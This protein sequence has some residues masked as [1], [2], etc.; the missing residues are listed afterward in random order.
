[1]A[2]YV[3][4]G[5]TPLRG[6]ITTNTTKN[7]TIAI[8][9]ASLM[10]KGKVVIKDVPA[11]EEVPRIIEI[12]E[13]IGVLVSWKDQHTIEIDSSNSLTL[14]DIHKKAC[15]R[16]RA[17]LLLMGALAGRA[18][19]TYKLYKSGGCKLGKRTVRPHVYAL[20]KLGI[21]VASK[22]R[23]YEVTNKKLQAAD[24]VMYEAG[25][26][27]TENAIMAAVLASGKT[28][29]KFASANY[30][31]QD[32]CYFLRAAGAKI[33]G[34]GTTTLTITGV[35]NL[36]SVT[37]YAIMPDPIEAFAWISLGVT[38]QSPI[39]IKNCPVDF[40][41]L[42][43]EKLRIMGQKFSFQK[44]RTSKNGTFRIADIVLKP[45][46]LTALQDKISCQPFPGLNID[47][48]PFFGPIATQ[49]EGRTLIH[50]WVYENRALYHLEMQKLGANVMLLDPH[51]VMIEGKTPLVANEALCPPAIRPGMALLIAMVAAKGQSK[52]RNVYPIERAYSDVEERLRALGADIIRE[53]S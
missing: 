29:I 26:T 51:R 6:S 27:P 49:A 20:E 40:L 4:E 2:R 8:L 52:L 22:R 43:L 3:I 31:V 41:E 36:R 44:K 9:C 50:D 45:S 25:D 19:G 32:L 53:E 15:E 12:L 5:G 10:I 35:K 24:I 23:W 17:S 21:H 14:D 1:M 46:I 47:N 39:T 48:L 28:T 38:T 18:K 16:T 13:S 7:S 11:I 34:I 33:K 37:E 30:M 42:E